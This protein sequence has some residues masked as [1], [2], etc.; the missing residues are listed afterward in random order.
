MS[1]SIT[2]GP[3]SPGPEAFSSDAVFHVEP[4]PDAPE[5]VLFHVEPSPAPQLDKPGL[6]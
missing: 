1:D 6:L 5:P 3:G 2:S 4:R